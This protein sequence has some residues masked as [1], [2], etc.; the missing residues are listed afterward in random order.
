MST[1]PAGDHTAR[2]PWTPAKKVHLSRGGLPELPPGD[3]AAMVLSAPVDEVRHTSGYPA[4]PKYLSFLRA[5]LPKTT[6]KSEK[7]NVAKQNQ[8]TKK[9][10]KKKKDHYRNPKTKNEINVYAK[11]AKE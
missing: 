10:L 2:G 11:Y 5:K 3:Q 4:A 7:G 8:I 1:L 9:M 6:R